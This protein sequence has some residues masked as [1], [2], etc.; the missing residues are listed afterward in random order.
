MSS[1]MT[2][3]NALKP[4]NVSRYAAG[5]G[6]EAQDFIKSAEL[7]SPILC[8]PTLSVGERILQS[9]RITFSA[10]ACNTNLGM[11]MLFAPLVRAA[12]IGR[13]SLRVH[14][15][16][17][18]RE[19]D[20][21]DT[22]Y[23]FEAIRT[24]APGGL[25]DSRKYDVNTPLR[26][27]TTLQRAMSEAG[28]RD[29]IAR[30]YM[31]D[32]ADIFSY[33]LPKLQSFTT[34][35]G[36]VEWAATGCYMGFMTELPDSHIARKFGVALAEKI[37]ISALPIAKALQKKDNPADATNMLLAFDKELKEQGINPGSNADL[38][39]T[40]LLAYYLQEKI[41]CRD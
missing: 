12:E 22:A 20:A 19:L 16:T 33:G 17:V 31:T 36:S 3:L 32:F 8:D 6:M 26:S 7:T 18:L 15:G 24:A 11:L 23:V 34:R 40:S 9:V 29:L 25:G 4:G 37:K 21:Q 38:V 28:H 30:Q 13:S 39:A 27:E 5:H 14:L 10:V 35:W 1:F 41:K 2:E